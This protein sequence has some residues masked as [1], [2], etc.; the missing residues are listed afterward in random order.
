[1]T[2]RPDDDPA[3]FELL[4]TI[5][6]EYGSPY[7]LQRR[8]RNRRAPGRVLRLARTQRNGATVSVV[9][10]PDDARRVARALNDFAE[11]VE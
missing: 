3:R 7:V 9:F 11:A 5:P 2:E 10:G 6:A 4:A 1:M 8:T